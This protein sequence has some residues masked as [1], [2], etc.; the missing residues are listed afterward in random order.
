METKSGSKIEKLVT[1]TPGND[2]QESIFKEGNC[3]KLK[4]EKEKLQIWEK[5]YP[6]MTPRVLEF[7]EHEEGLKASLVMEYLQGVHLQE[8]VLGRNVQMVRRGL[9]CLIKTV[10]EIWKNTLSPEPVNA[11]F[12]GQL[13]RKIREISAVHPHFQAETYAIGDFRLA[14]L[15]ELL[16]ETQSFEH[17]L[18]AP[19]HVL[20]HG[21]FNTDNIIFNAEQDKIYYIDL[22]RSEH[23]DYLQ[24]VS[25]FLISNFRAPIFDRFIRE[26]INYVTHVFYRFAVNFARQFGDLTFAPRLS[27]GLARSFATS[28]RF[29][30]KKDFAREMYMRS[31]FILERLI[32][33]HKSGKP[34][35]E[36]ILDENVLLYHR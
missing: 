25:V 9:K 15:E 27:L 3:G 32:R 19:F 18:D 6:G 5:D 17:E 7:H 10:S 13:Q 31:L 12:M 30:A 34:W 4:L 2:I 22:H 33:F 29:A 35:K 20:I 26:R 11:G 1:V 28:T 8:I 16:K 21:D 36:Y 23:G 14:T 24:D